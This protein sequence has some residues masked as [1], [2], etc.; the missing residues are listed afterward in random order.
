[1]YLTVWYLSLRNTQISPNL[2]NPWLKCPLASPATRTCDRARQC[3]FGVPTALIH[4]SINDSASSTATHLCSSN[5]R[6]LVDKF[7]IDR[8]RRLHKNLLR[9]LLTP[10]IL[11]EF[12]HTYLHAWT[13][14]QLTLDCC[15]LVRSR[16]H[17]F[18]AVSLFFSLFLARHNAHIV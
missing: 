5:N 7:R 16:K 8:T 17:Q 11:T 18:R 6:P 12:C 13:W 1:M 10:A 15:L 4:R 14:K 9:P 2:F 3:S